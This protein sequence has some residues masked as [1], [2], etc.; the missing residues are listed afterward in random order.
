MEVDIIEDDGYYEFK[1]G[2]KAKLCFSVF[3]EYEEYF[4]EDLNVEDR[5]EFFKLTQYK[6]L[7]FLE[8]LEVNRSYRNQGLS[9]FLMDYFIDY[10]KSQNY[11]FIYL[12]ASPCSDR[13]MELDDLTSF[14]KRKGFDVF[15]DQRTN[16]LMINKL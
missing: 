9:S 6:P 14:Y 10:I 3:Y 16:R 1:I 5:K 7:V 11:E 8:H 4:D 2:E 13:G 15:K 12:N